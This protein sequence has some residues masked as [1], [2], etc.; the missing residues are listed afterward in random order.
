[1]W[2]AALDFIKAALIL[3]IDFPHDGLHRHSRAGVLP[4]EKY[5]KHRADEHP[6]QADDDNDQDRHPTTCGNSGYQGFR[7]CDNRLDRS[8]RRPDCC[9]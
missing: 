5:P 2:I 8:H 1:M 3:G 6:D 7:A 9:F 4:G